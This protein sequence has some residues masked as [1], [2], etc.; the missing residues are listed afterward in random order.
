MHSQVAFDALIFFFIP[1]LIKLILSSS[2]TH[3]D[4]GR[5]EVRLILRTKTL[6]EGVV[7]IL[8]K[9]VLTHG[10]INDALIPGKVKLIPIRAGITL[11]D[12]L[13]IMRV[14]ARTTSAFV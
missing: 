12:G 6:F 10:L 7:I 8:L 11:S 5:S 3:T 2:A 13:V 4:M 14:F 9:V 1:I